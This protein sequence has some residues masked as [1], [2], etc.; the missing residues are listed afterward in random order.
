VITCSRCG[1][2]N[3]KHYK[4][5]LGCGAKLEVPAPPPPTASA[6]AAS[7]PAAAPAR[8]K[9]PPSSAPVAASPGP[10]AAL[11]PLVEVG[12]PGAAAAFPPTPS[13]LSK[14][15]AGISGSILTP[16]PSPGPLSPPPMQPLTDGGGSGT[17]GARDMIACPSCGKMVVSTYAFCGS[18]GQRMKPA[19]GGPASAARTM[20]MASGAPAARPAPRG[21]LTLI[22]PDGTEGGVHPLHEAEN[23]IGR[24]QGAL[25]DADPYLSPR[26]AEFSFTPEGL[27]VRDLRSLN[28][29]FIKIMQEEKL[30]SGDVLRIGQELL[31]FDAISPPVPLEDGTE[32]IGTPN[33]GF[34][35][36]VSVIVG[37]DVDGP[38]F[39]LFDETVVLGRERGDILFPEDG[40]VS[41]TH[42]QLTLRNGHVYLS[43]LGSSNGTFFRIRGSR[44]IPSGSLLLMGQQLFRASFR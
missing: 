18:C 38:A 6:A 17:V 14:R 28:G 30:E 22:R 31:R 41:G 36:R 5:C 43:D 21:H 35:G 12:I 32:I 15:P 19:A 3:Q 39:P 44:V 13:G 2:E 25:F 9:T 42:A 40:Y 7:E 29:V 27:M 23:L 33:P 37:R 20:Y 26:H 11:P 4:F 16:T 34:W 1:K 24:G 8:A 10:A